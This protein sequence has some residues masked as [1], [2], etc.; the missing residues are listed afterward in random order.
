MHRLKIPLDRDVIFLAEAGAEG[1]SS[2]GIDF[3]V[4]KHWDTIA[5]EFALNEGGTIYERGGRVQY[6]GVSTTEK[7]S[8]SIRLVVD[9]SG[10]STNFRGTGKV[11]AFSH[12][13]ISGD[14]V[15]AATLFCESRSRAFLR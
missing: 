7:I 8:R 5:C 11:R 15:A 4:E 3:M 6:V 14:T 12:A 2:A 10:A 9:A 1:T 13:E